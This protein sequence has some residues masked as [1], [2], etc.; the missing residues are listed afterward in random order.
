[1]AVMLSVTTTRVGNLVS[2]GFL[3]WPPGAAASERCLRY[4][5]RGGGFAEGEGPSE[6]AGSSL[7]ES[8]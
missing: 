3:L 4:A 7:G 6:R 8:R 5:Q 2:V 1:M